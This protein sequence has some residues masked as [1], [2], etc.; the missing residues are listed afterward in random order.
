MDL[1]IYLNEIIQFGKEGR[2]G[3]SWTGGNSRLLLSLDIGSIDWNPSVF[4][5]LCLVYFQRLIYMETKQELT[6]FYVFTL[7]I[8]YIKSNSFLIKKK[9]NPKFKIKRLN[10]NGIVPKLI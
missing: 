4:R 5:S 8:L 6:K 10:L 7:I 1:S 3:T 2:K 9:K